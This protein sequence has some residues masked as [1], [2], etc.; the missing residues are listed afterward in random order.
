PAGRTYKKLGE[1]IGS[2]AWLRLAATPLLA[3]RRHEGPLRGPFSVLRRTSQRGLAA[4]GAAAPE[5]VGDRGRD[6]RRAGVSGAETRGRR[7]ARPLVAALPPAGI[8]G[9]SAA[10]PVSTR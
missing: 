9:S 7:R 8:A 2:H 6:P 3:S 1:E 5:R 4:Q 10:A